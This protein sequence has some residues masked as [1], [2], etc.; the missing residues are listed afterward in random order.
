MLQIMLEEQP[1]L[2][3]REPDSRNRYVAWID[4][5]GMG[6]IASRSISEASIKNFKLHTA[7][8]A[9]YEGCSGSQKQTLD[10]YPMMDGVY[11]VGSQKTP[12]M[13]LL[14]SAYQVLAQD[15]VD[16]EEIHHVLLLK[17]SI[18][19][20]PII[21]GKT[22]NGVNDLLAGTEHE[23]R[24][25]VGLP[26]IQAFKAEDVAPPF[27]IRV[28]ESARAFAPEEDHPFNF[29]WWKWFKSSREEYDMSS[30]ASEL[31]RK[32]EEYFDWCR[33]NSKRLDY[34]EEDIGRHEGLV[35]QYLPDFEDE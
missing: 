23:D 34:D 24:T 29:T 25:M 19:Y 17:G 13:V 7:F 4:V 20:G 14:S 27:G 28:H 30:L 22:S 12:L 3:I 10:M 16:A 31:H 6:S 15:V 33:N 1:D 2:F 11:V 9:A 26:V 32:L 18:A 5:M 35:D 8:V 21:Q